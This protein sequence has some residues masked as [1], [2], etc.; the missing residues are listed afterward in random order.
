[1][2]LVIACVYWLIESEESTSI[3]PAPN[4]LSTSSTDSSESFEK[5]DSLTVLTL[6]SKFSMLSNS[7]SSNNDANFSA[8]VS[9]SPEDCYLTT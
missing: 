5:Y 1:M 7:I 6:T 2:K 8:S 4:K 9:A 3:S